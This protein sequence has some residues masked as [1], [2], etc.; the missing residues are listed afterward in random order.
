MMTKETEHLCLRCFQNI[1]IC[2]TNVRIAEQKQIQFDYYGT[3]RSRSIADIDLCV[4]LG[5]A[6]DNAVAGC[7][8]IDSGRSIRLISQSEKSLLS[9]VVSNSFDGRVQQA[10]DKILSRKR[11]NRAG[12]GLVSMK[13]ICERYGGSMQT[14]WDENKFTVM[15]LLP[16]KDE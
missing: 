4:L 8:T 14:Q 2:T 9:I 16:L 3:I 12:V 6:L 11:E 1:W 13:S 5:N 10:E 15:F 7:M